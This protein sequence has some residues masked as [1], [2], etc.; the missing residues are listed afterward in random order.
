MDKAALLNLLHQ[1]MPADLW[2]KGLA[3]VG[4]LSLAKQAVPR[5]LAWGVPAAG[6]AAD[7]LAKAAL[8]SPL[9][10]LI[11][12]QAPA[13]IA[14]LD[15]LTAALTQILDTFKDELEKDLKAAEV[16][17][18]PAAQTPDEKKA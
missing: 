4:A 16:V 6:R 7:W 10:P 12:W 11:L 9:R 3:V 17:V 14:F 13:L 15:S 2:Q 5:F 18:V 8:N 1:A